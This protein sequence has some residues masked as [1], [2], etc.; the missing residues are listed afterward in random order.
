MNHI[1]GIDRNQLQMICLDQLVASESMVRVIDAFVDILDLEDLGFSY[2]KL[3]KEGRPPFHPADML[4]IY[5]YGYQNSIRSCRKLEKACLVNLEMIWLTKGRSPHFKTLAKFRKENHKAFKMVFRHFVLVLKNWGLIEGETIAIDSFKI[6]AQNSLKNNFNDRKIKR[7]LDY[8]DKKI[9]VYEA[10]L[11]KEFSKEIACKI[12]KQNQKKEQYLLAKE[13]LQA[14]EDGQI[15]TTDPD[16]RAVVFQRNSVKIGYNIQAASDAKH[17]MLIAADTGDVNDT[18]AL[19]PMV[20]LTQKNIRE[21]NQPINVLADKGYHS[22]REIKAIKELNATTF[23]SPK[24]S[25]SIKKNPAFAMESFLYN[26]EEDTYTCPA[27]NTMNTN[28]KWYNKNLKNGRKSYHV[29]HYKTKACKECPLRNQ[30]TQNK[31]GRIIERTEYAQYVQ[32]NNTRVNQNPDYYRQR[33]QIIEH[34]FGTLKRHRHFD[35]TLMK[36]KLNVMSEVYI[37]FTLYNL[38]RSLSILQ[39]P[40]LID[41]L[42]GLKRTFSSIFNLS[43]LFIALRTL[44]NHKY[45]VPTQTF[46]KSK[47]LILT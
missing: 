37:Q 35:Y 34:Q 27:G 25:S 24:E 47:T 45:Y 41:K 31:L 19:S 30:C 42:K 29:K 36:G 2:F 11:D 33:Q 16:S 21:S 12:D 28:G 3:N 15:S 43:A 44:P 17:K 8:I 14:T 13:Q 32:E 4:K 7:H 23:I 1:E 38:T 22:G 46:S 18:K 20:E 9:A 6:R 40:Q 39:F 5:L 10:E 26:E